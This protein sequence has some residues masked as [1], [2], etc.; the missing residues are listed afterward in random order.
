MSNIEISKRYAKAF[1]LTVKE[2]KQ[3]AA[4]YADLNLISSVVKNT[5]EVGAFFANPL[6]G[7][8]LKKKAL[9][10][11][12]A[13]SFQSKDTMKII[14]LLAENNRLSILPEVAIA[15]RNLMDAEMGITRGEVVSAEEMASEDK[16]SLE[17]QLAKTLGKKI[18]LNYKTDR[19]L[20]GGVVVT[21]GGMKFDDTLKTHL[22]NMNDELHRRAH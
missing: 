17:S 18:L 5:A 16:A 14:E 21:V 15:F 1:Y 3:D 11:A 4:A 7:L 10:E 19:S 2:D 8:E 22:K 12:I 6:I 13:T 20:M 9:Q